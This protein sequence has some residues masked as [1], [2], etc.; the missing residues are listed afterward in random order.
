MVTDK[1]DLATDKTDLNTNKAGLSTDKTGM[2]Y[3]ILQTKCSHN[4]F[5]LLFGF[6]FL[7][8]F[9][10]LQIFQHSCCLIFSS[11]QIPTDLSKSDFDSLA[12]HITRSAN[13][14]IE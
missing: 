9:T 3:K 1:R 12:G 10:F 8:Q 5:P 14:E 11:R 2:A 7:L 6:V 4:S 13:S